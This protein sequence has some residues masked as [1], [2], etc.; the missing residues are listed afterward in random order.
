MSEDVTLGL[1][2]AYTVSVA[3]TGEAGT[4]S[5]S[6]PDAVFH[7]DN[8]RTF[9]LFGNLANDG[10]IIVNPVSGGSATQFDFEADATI[11]GNG[12]LRL[13][14]FAAR[15]RLRTGA[16]LTLTQNAGHTIAG[17][18]QIEAALV[19]GG[20]V[21]ADVTGQELLLIFNDKSNNATMRA[22]S[23][24]ILDLSSI[25][26]T[27][28]GAGLLTADG[29][30]SRVDLNGTTVIGGELSATGGAT[31]ELLS[32]TLDGI[33][34][35]QGTMN[36]QNT[37]TLDVFNSI[38]NDGVIVVNPVAGGSATQLDFENDGSFLGSGSVLLNSFA[39]RAR[40]RTAPGV[41]MTNSATHTI[42]GYGQIEAALINDGLV[43]ADNSMGNEMF[44]VTDDKINNA[45]MQAINTGKL[46]F[47]AISI[48]QTG[49]GEMVADGVGSR[50]DF[51]STTV[52][53]GLIRSIN[54]A[55]IDIASGT[56][57]AVMVE[58]EIDLLNARTLDVV[59]SIT[60]N[61]TI[62]INPIS[63]GSG[64][65]LDFESTGSFLGNG[66]VVLNSFDSRARLR[67]G[68][69]FTMTNSA[70]HTIRGFGRIEAA[71]INDGLVNADVASQELFF[72]NDDKVNNS[73]MQAINEGILDFGVISIDQSGGGLIIADGLGSRVDL[74]STNIVGGA[75]R[76]IND[77]I[78]D[79][80]SAS[81]D[82]VV[83]DA[84]ARIRN[85]RTLTIQ[86]SVTN[87]RVITVNSDAGG[88]ATT[89]QWL[90]D[91][92]LGGTGTVV[93]NSFSTRA[94]IT[95]AG[96]ATTAT[97]G[98]G[99]RL[100][101]FGNIDAPLMH[102]GTTAPGMSIGTMLA[103]QPITYSDSS[104]FEAEVDG[105]SSDL[106]DSSSSITIDG[107]LEVQ[108]IDGFAPTGYWARKIMEGSSIT[109]KFDAVIVPPA[110]SGFVTR[111]YND[112]SNLYVGQT[113]PSDTNL[114]G[115]LN[116]FDVSVFL[117]NYNMGNSAADL[118]GDGQLNFFDV[119][120]FLNSYNMGC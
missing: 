90:D 50:I 16:G 1:L 31:I 114:D 115:V 88:S 76:T 45:T 80:A 75:V 17:Y 79:I 86:N 15:A 109:G 91:T 112:G 54:G 57:D 38:T 24:A 21:Q 13:N 4:L 44:L 49:G 93:L 26:L 32:A 82:G 97:L 69:G 99:Q 94:R 96:A 46:D 117:N 14:S 83:L 64:T 60:N 43:S 48:D 81:L 5:I 20:M 78:L 74:N 111:V 113:C 70:T 108:F 8:F 12:E 95:M 3:S 53:G 36:L 102:H 23:G 62:T 65:Q 34:L 77:A 119:S 100:E 89:L 118:N 10:M 71:L 7:I 98:A 58:G 61:G 56:F 22:I 120:T 105:T 19:N 59:N 11:S 47:G 103:T 29:A 68:P 33:N 30:G 104:L 27:Q 92:A 85:A 41:S 42:H 6:N 9:N 2:G 107:T 39:T 67:T 101:G 55:R 28:S 40:L 87:N 66:E 37:R 52:I 18:G 35:S 25:T 110:P 72:A 51:N 73:T 116:F 106:L 63:G 84:D